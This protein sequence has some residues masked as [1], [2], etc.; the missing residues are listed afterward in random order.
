[1]ALGLLLLIFQ[2]RIFIKKYIQHLAPIGL[3]CVVLPSPGLTPKPSDGLEKMSHFAGD[4]NIIANQN[5]SGRDR[6]VIN[7]MGLKVFKTHP[8]FGVGPRGYANYVATSFDRELPGENKWDVN[9]VINTRNENIWVELLVE[10]GLIFTLLVL[11]LLGFYLWPSP[12]AHRN[13]IYWGAWSSLVL[14]YSLSGQFSQNILLTLVFSIWGI[15]IYA[16]ELETTR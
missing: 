4:L 5:S 12:L 8:F 10:N 1:M 16:Q 11:A 3:L 15:F 13:P 14:Y 9:H 7:L 6:L 2:R